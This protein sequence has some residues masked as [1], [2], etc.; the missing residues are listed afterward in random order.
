V[1]DRLRTV[2]LCPLNS[3][4]T[5][6]G[7]FLL[8]FHKFRMKLL[9]LSCR[10]SRNFKHHIYQKWAITIY[11]GFLSFPSRKIRK[12]TSCFFPRMYYCF[13]IYK[14]HYLGVICRYSL[15]PITESRFPSPNP[16]VVTAAKLSTSTKEHSVIVTHALS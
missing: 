1:S 3:L 14:F 15:Y 12:L 16:M 6:F 13:I 4:S 11:M 8:P 9:I 7:T 10:C 2:G 5:E